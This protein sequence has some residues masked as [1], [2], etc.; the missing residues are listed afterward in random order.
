MSEISQKC[1]TWF[2]HSTANLVKMLPDESAE[3]LH[4]A[5]G[6][7]RNVRKVINAHGEF[8]SGSETNERTKGETFFPQ[9][10]TTHTFARKSRAHRPPLAIR[11]L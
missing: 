6:A 3:K 8:V 10:S 1:G 5:S 4:G 2:V 9:M 7:A 11:V